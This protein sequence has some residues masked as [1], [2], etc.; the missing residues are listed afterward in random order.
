MAYCNQ[1]GSELTEG[2]E[3][4]AACGAAVPS[5]Q[6]SSPAPPPGPDVTAAGG[7]ASPQVI[8][9]SVP[10]ERNMALLCHLISFVGFFVPF[11]NIVG[12]LV[13]WLVKR[14][15][16]PFVDHH[17]KEA[18]NFQISLTIYALASLLLMLILVGFLLLPAVVVFGI[19]MVIIAAVRANEGVEYRY[20][21]TIRLVT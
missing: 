19:V 1:C 7:A 20:P 6:G 16:S 15:Q 18:L 11:G 5:A 3:F 2:A 21:L 8:R 4:C 17:G 10:E 13:V 9:L 12:P 14:E